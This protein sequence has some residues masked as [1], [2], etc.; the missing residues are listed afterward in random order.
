MAADGDLR[1][2]ASERSGT[3]ISGDSIMG[4][5]VALARLGPGSE[6]GPYELVSRVKLGELDV[7]YLASDTRSGAPV[8]LR[9]LRPDADRARAREHYARLA[10]L[11]GP[12]FAEVLEVGE[13]AGVLFVAQTFGKGM[14]LKTWLDTP[15]SAALPW[16]ARLDAVR[17]LLELLAR[18]H[19]AGLTHGALRPELLRMLERDQLELVEFPPPLEAPPR[20]PDASNP[21]ST[22]LAPE[23]LEGGR[24]DARSD[25]FSACALVYELVYGEHPFAASNPALTRAAQL[26]GRV[27]PST[28]PVP[29]SLRAVLL[30]GLAADPNQRWPSMQALSEA[31]SASHR[32]LS[33]RLAVGLGVGLALVLG[34]LAALMLS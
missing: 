1:P 24:A 4:P 18:A 7:R 29:A 13:F 25:Q 10:Q 5:A 28:Q 20:V 15:A 8:L 26:A 31:L 17:E 30:R 14:P 34:M 19:E 11:R 32:S 9:L 3:L 21:A 22:Y 12:G 16:P 27:R 33:P 6:L 2:P 23:Q